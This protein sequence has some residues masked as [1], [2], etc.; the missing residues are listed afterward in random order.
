[1]LFLPV[2][3]INEIAWMG[4]EVSFNDEWIELKNNTQEEISLDGWILKAD[5]GTPEISLAGKIPAKG[6]YLLERTDDDTVQEIT[7]DLIYKG[8]LG[9]SGENLKLFDVSGNL[10]DEVNCQDGWLAGDNGAKLTMERTES[11][12][13]NSAE[14][15]GT[16]K[17]ENS[18]GIIITEVGPLSTYP[19][20]IIFS[21]I[22]PSPEG[23]DAENEWIKIY[24]QNDFEVD[25]SGW[26]IKDTIGRTTT[27]T[28]NSKIKELSSL[29]LS[30]PE[31]KITLNNDGDGLELINP[32][33]EIVDSVTFAEASLGQSYIRTSSGWQW[34]DK[35]KLPEVG[36]RAVEKQATIKQSNKQSE[37]RPLSLSEKSSK[38]PP[39][40]IALIVA[41]F[42]G[43]AIV[44]LNNRLSSE[45]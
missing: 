45:F 14:P 36:P 27:Y 6:F 25:L 22:L 32:N 10:V 23:P 20:G 41:L 5:D 4:T 1:M 39:I 19:A 42:S 9:N 15:G 34:Q 7:A 33:G 2:V 30:R 31:T 29:I 17:A 11:G 12:W 21:E 18:A 26:Q 24:N 35:E 43:A 3:T 8:A 28:L 16:P 13:E 40:F 38:V 37:T 44:Y